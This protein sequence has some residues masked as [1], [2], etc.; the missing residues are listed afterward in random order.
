[1]SINKV[2]LIGRLG[3]EPEERSTPNGLTICKF[4]LATTFYYKKQEGTEWHSIVCFGELA[5][6]CFKH[7][8][9][10]MQV[11]V[12]GSLKTDCVEKN[13]EKKYYTNV[14]AGVVR[15]LS[16]KS[17]DNSPENGGIPF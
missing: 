4:S 13:G 16:P 5:K 14:I 3:S 15:F 11:Y 9:K 6:N 1:M 17:K 2:I 10:G 7:C 8:N 12:E